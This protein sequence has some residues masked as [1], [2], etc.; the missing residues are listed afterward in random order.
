MKIAGMHMPA[1]AEAPFSSTWWVTSNVTARAAPPARYRPVRRRSSEGVSGCNV[2]LDALTGTGI[3]AQHRALRS[4]LPKT[5]KKRKKSTWIGPLD[6]PIFPFP[7]FL[8][9]T[10]NRTRVELMDLHFR[11]APRQIPSVPQSPLRF[12]PLFFVNNS[13]LFTTK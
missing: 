1:A 9:Q 11:H 3:I 5:K 12:I 6:P 13:S 4:Q 8:P 7:F 10:I 2:S